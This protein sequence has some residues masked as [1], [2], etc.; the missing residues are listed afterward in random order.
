L[1]AE[2]VVVV[3]FARRATREGDGDRYHDGARVLM[4]HG[5]TFADEA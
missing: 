5:P 3:A 2:F 4:G 1:A